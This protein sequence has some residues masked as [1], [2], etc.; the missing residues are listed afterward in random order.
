MTKKGRYYMAKKVT[1]DGITFDSQREG[2]RY[3]ELKILK[4]AGVIRD[5]KL[6][7]RFPITIA[8]V[9]IFFCGSNR[10]LTYVADFSYYDVEKRKTIIEDAKGHKTEV[11]KIK[12]ALMRAMGYEIVEV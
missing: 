6:Q 8:G 11:Y 4:H 10:H 5:L 2:K 1:I 3:G 9:D 12:R 7:P